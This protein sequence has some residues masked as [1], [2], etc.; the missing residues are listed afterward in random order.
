MHNVKTTKNSTQFIKW[1]DYPG[2][3]T[4]GLFGLALL[5]KTIS[6]IFF[7]IYTVNR[8]FWSFPIELRR[9]FLFEYRYMLIF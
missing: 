7:E 2:R 8:M 9:H 3:S 6:D 5:E 1:L 4:R